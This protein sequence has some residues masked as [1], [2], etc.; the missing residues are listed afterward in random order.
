MTTN[1]NNAI[2][3]NAAYGGRTSANAFNDILTGFSRGILS[4]WVCS[5]NS[6]LTV[7]LGGSGTTRDVALAEN[8]TGDKVTINNISNAPVDVTIGAAPA[9]NS[10]IDAIVA[11][12]DNPPQGTSTVA[13]NPSACGLITVAGIAASTPTAPSDSSI[14]TAITADG[15]SG[16]T[17]Y[18]VVLAYVT[19]AA[20]TTDIDADNISSGEYAGVGARNIN[21]PSMTAYNIQTLSA[22]L[23]Q[24]FATYTTVDLSQIPDGQK[25]VAI[26]TINATGTD[27]LTALQ[28][29]AQYDSVNSPSSVIATQWGKSIS[30]IAVFT[31]VSGVNSLYIQAKKDNST[32]SA[33]N[34][35]ECVCYA[36]G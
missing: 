15:A 7:S 35:C 24:T 23:T 11:Y 29:R 21:F 20:G 19:I 33:I 25:F 32:S 27:T 34:T 16:T 4:G 2:G 6:G 10:R 28:G 5:P 14:R 36:I 1:P 8:N 13:D 26:F 31:K 9:S 3:T 17:A 22:Q 18:Y 12:V 30:G